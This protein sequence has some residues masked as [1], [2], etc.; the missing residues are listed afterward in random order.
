MVK[1]SDLRFS[2]LSIATGKPVWGTSGQ[3]YL[4][5][6]AHAF[7]SAYDKDGTP[8]FRN[9]PPG[10]YKLEVKAPRHTYFRGDTVVTDGKNEE[11]TAVLSPAGAFYWS[12]HN[13]NGVPLVG[14]KCALTPDDPSSLEVPR[15]GHTD[16]DGDW[17]LYDLLPGSYTATATSANGRTVTERV[18][19]VAGQDVKETSELE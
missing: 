5:S 2:A 4:P 19:I 16:P 3:L 17:E 9:V 10:K 12:L 6:G 15:E 11:V 7:Y 1:G 13:R 18:N 14:V 8:V